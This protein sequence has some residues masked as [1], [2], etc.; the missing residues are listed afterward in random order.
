[1]KSNKQ[2]ITR[3]FDGKIDNFIDKE[4][5]RHQKKMLRA[6]LRGDTH[7]QNGWINLKMKMPKLFKVEQTYI[8]L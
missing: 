6:Y 7:F 3:T 2:K 5:A 8:T 4:D 1:M